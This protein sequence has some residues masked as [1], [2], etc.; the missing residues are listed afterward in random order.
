M[1]PPRQL[2][3]AGDAVH[4][5][6]RTLQ[7]QQLG[8]EE[9][10]VEGGVVDD[11]PVLTE[12]LQELVGDVGKQRLILQKCPGQPVHRDHLLGH[13]ALRVDEA[14]ELAPRRD[15]VQQLDAADLEQAVAALRVEPGRFGVEDDF[16]HATLCRELPWAFKPSA[17]RRP[18]PDAP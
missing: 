17:A 18:R 3:R 2:Q 5:D 10:D 4:G 14:V 11:E 1:A 12:E 7:A 8:I 16:A 13:V 6:R 9:A 15:A